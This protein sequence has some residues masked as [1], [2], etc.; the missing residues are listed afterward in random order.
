MVFTFPPS[1]RLI[2][3]KRE[4]NKLLRESARLLREQP[5]DLR[6]IEDKLRLLG[7]YQWWYENALK[8]LGPTF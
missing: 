5:P 8:Q 1:F 7:A 4:M 3:A 6:K 2:Y